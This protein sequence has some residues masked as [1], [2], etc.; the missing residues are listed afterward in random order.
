MEDADTEWLSYIYLWTVDLFVSFATSFLLLLFVFSLFDLVFLSW[1]F[2][3]LSSICL[4]LFSLLLFF[5]LIESMLHTH[6]PD[7]QITEVLILHLFLLTSK[8][9]L[10][11]VRAISF[12]S[13]GA[14]GNPMY[15]S[16]YPFIPH[17]KMNLSEQGPFVHWLT[18]EISIQSCVYVGHIQLFI[19]KILVYRELHIWMY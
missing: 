10:C 4:L 1:F 6:D 15:H 7:I 13:T 3:P 12:T 11:R 8:P 19:F 18:L 14:N 17:L 2:L 5:Q 9:C 16:S